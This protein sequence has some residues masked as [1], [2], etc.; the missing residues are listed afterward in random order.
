M[1]FLATDAWEK[2]VDEWGLWCLEMCV[3][4]AGQQDLEGLGIVL[5]PWSRGLLLSLTPRVGR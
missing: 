1:L 3:A 2:G 4:P 5:S